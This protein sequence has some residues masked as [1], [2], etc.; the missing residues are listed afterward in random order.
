MGRY[1]T[2]RLLGEGGMGKVYLARQLDLGR[3]VVVKV[4]HDHVA[5][6]QKF[7]DRFTRETLL[8]AR[9][10]HPYA[11]TLYDA[12]VND[13]QGPC[14]VMEYI[15]GMTLDQLLQNTGRFTPHRVG[16]LL[17]MLCEVLQAAH[18]L[19]IVHRD[20]KPANLMIVDAGTPYELLKVMDF[21]LAKLLQPDGVPKVT[22][23]NTEFAVGTPGY[24]CPEQARGEPMDGRGDLYSV[25]IILYEL[26]TGRLPFAGK[27]TMD[28]LLAQVTEEPPPFAFVATDHTVPEPIERVVKRC[29]AKDPKDRPQQA[30]DLTVL[31][32]AALQN[33]PPDTP[34][35]LR[36]MP[37][38]PTQR[39]RIDP[40]ESDSKVLLDAP[41]P[42]ESLKLGGANR[43]NPRPLPANGP[44]SPAAP[45]SAR[46]YEPLD[47][48]HHLEAWMPEKI[49][50][51]KLRGFVGDVGGDI[52]E[53]IPGRI[54]VQVGGKGSIYYSRS[55]SSLSWLGLGR[56]WPIDMTLHLEH[57]DGGRENHLL[58]TV[59]FRAPSH[60]LGTDIGWRNLCTQIFCDLRAYLMGQTNSLRTEPIA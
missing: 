52:L 45:S 48:V 9:F 8:M 41:P 46:L 16:R 24:M 42:L 30:R 26:L 60:E 27:S 19:G 11:V 2:I 55:G 51:F 21:G 31:Y 32:E 43:E 17:F 4:M 5:A 12:S 53:S 37:A 44:A 18:Q 23:T 34:E 28:V 29:L 13:P 14:I 6:D 58:I 54:R 10:Q 38:P 50:A 33:Q 56:R 20:L 57:G 47:V 3:Q 15:R 35:P 59:V 49:A 40:P 22:V 25:G 36:T 7:R 39:P 1:E